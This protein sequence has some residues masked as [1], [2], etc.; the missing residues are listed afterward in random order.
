[1]RQTGAITA[2]ASGWSMAV[3]ACAR[4]TDTSRRRGTNERRRRA[5]ACRSVGPATLATLL[6]DHLVVWRDDEHVGGNRVGGDRRH[7]ARDFH[8]A[9]LLHHVGR[10]TRALER[11]V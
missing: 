8:R 2:S 11:H 10:G 1:M 6:L 7:L 3:T 5:E 9:H 4:E